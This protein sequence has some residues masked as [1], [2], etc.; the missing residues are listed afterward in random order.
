M[1]IIQ[2]SVATRTR[3]KMFSRQENLGRDT[4]SK[5]QHN[6]TVVT[7]KTLL[8]L[9]AKKKH[10]KQVATDDCKLQQEPTTKKQKVGHDKHFQVATEMAT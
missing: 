9:K 3:T 10:R 6:I 8:R 5:M 7:K 4:N 2:D 1:P